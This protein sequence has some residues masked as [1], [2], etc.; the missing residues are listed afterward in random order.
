MYPTKVFTV[1]AIIRLLRTLS[2]LHVASASVRDRHDYAVQPISNFVNREKTG[3]QVGLS[4]HTFFYAEI[5]QVLTVSP[6]VSV[7]VER[8]L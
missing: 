8:Q 2:P 3:I 7:I 5:S 4:T 6:L 1:A